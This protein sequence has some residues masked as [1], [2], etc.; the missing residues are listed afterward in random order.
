MH[1]FC[2]AVTFSF[3]C[4]PRQLR[5]G[6]GS[7]QLVLVASNYIFLYARRQVP[8]KLFD[9]AHGCAHWTAKRTDIY[10]IFDQCERR[11]GVPQAAHF[12]SQLW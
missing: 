2:F 11:M 8:V 7:R 1:W 9:H 4:G 10:A 5:L 3:F 12:A 6:L